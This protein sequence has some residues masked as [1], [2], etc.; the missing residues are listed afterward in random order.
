MSKYESWGRFPKVN[1]EAHELFWLNDKWSGKNGRL[2]LPYGQG[3]S[4]GDSC[5]NQDGL[6][7]STKHL[8]RFISFDEQSGILKCEAGVTLA[9]ILSWSVPRGWFLP[10][11]PG[12]QFVSVA[13][14]IANDVHGKNHH[15]AGTFGRFVKG[16]ELKR[17]DGITHICSPTQNQELFSAT[18]G[19]LGLT[20][21]ILWAEVELKRIPSAFIKMESLKFSSLEEFFEI[22][23]GSAKNFEY[24]VAWLDCVASGSNFGRGIFMRGNHTPTDGKAPG[25]LKLAVPFDL[26][27]FTLNPLSIRLFNTAYYHRQFTK[28][29]ETVVHYRPFFYPLDGVENWNRI[30]GKPGFFQFQCVV[31]GKEEIKEILEQIVRSGEGSFLAVLKEFGEIE[32]PGM[33]SFPRPGVTLCLDFANRGSKTLGLLR[34]LDDLVSR[35]KGAMYPAKDAFMSGENFKSYYP[36]LPH[37]LKYKDPAFSSSFWRRVME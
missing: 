25:K 26:P 28:Q 20:G 4:Y 18:I 23:A 13:G 11:T 16:L 17:S 5:L 27:S 12:T 32:S 22:S 3:R 10:V 8:N 1:Q 14:A 31:P 37:F 24:T 7:L 9:Q 21:L 29:V 36:Q 30:Y 19:G 34:G 15:G 2:L 6:L 33:L 35:L